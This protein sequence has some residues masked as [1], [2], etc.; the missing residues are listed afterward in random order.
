[1][2]PPK[3]NVPAW[4]SATRER[5]IGILMAI[6]ALLVSLVA[7]EL[8][9]AALGFL[10]PVEHWYPGDREGV[11]EEHVV[12]SV[13]WTSR[14]NR[15]RRERPTHGDYDVTH[16]T[17]GWGFRDTVDYG[18]EHEGPRIAF[19]GDS[20]TTGVG[21]EHHD[22]F[23]ELVERSVPGSRA[24]NLGVTGHGVDQMWMV[25]R[26]YAAR[27]EPDLIVVSFIDDD[28]TRSL[29][30]YRGHR[31]RWIAKPVFRIRSGRLE[32]LTIENRPGSVRRW[33]EQHS[34]LLA[35]WRS[36]ERH[37]GPRYPAGERWKLNR[38]LFAK[39]RDEAA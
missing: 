38:A 27:V 16:T 33:L 7:V 34:R 36:L 22:T 31:E 4:R 11:S 25:V 24:Y 3:A 35:G 37:L 26:H 32:R 13:G 12:E 5:L 6:G 9:F 20:F 21:V 15:Q 30:A 19:I 8:I 2:I 10:E 14:P 39:I 17:N 18:T 29:S 23:A 1:M 28:M